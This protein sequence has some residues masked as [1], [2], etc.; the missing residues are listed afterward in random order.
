MVDL[1][2]NN[3]LERMKMKEAVTYLKVFSQG[4]A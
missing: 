4:F 2:M 3:K 1:L